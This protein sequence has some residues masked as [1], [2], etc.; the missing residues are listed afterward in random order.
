MKVL[1]FLYKEFGGLLILYL[2]NFVVLVLL[3]YLTDGLSTFYGILYFILLSLFFLLL[4]LI[5]MYHRRKTMYGRLIDRGSIEESIVFTLD[6]AISEEK[7]KVADYEKRYNEHLIF[8]D[9]WVHYIKTPLAVIR[10][11]IQE[12]DSTPAPANRPQEREADSLP[13]GTPQREFLNIQSQTTQD[14][15]LEIKNDEMNEETNEERFAQIQT[16]ADKILD[17]VNTALNYA[18]ATNFANDF[19]VEP[20]NIHDL[21]VSVV[22][23]LKRSFIRQNVFPEISIPDNLVLMT[24]KKWM[25]FILFQ[26]LTNA[27]KYSFS[28]GKV[29]ISSVSEDNSTKLRVEDSGVGIPKCDLNRVFDIFFTGENGRKQGESTGI[30]LYLVMIICEKLDYTLTVQSDV[31]K[32]SIFSVSLNTCSKR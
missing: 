19:V 18:R 25:S 5:L 30:G 28:G 27:I 4:Y 12:I 16:E 3:L 17:G 8:I 6:N 21:S 15:I 26:L 23:S 14:E 7:K 29:R 9:R 10:S 32:G 2:F 13:A 11:I 22:N 24:D 20:V 31:G 1:R